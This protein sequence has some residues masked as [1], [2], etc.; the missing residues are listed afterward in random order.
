MDLQILSDV[1]IPMRDAIC[2]LLQPLI[3]PFSAATARL[4]DNNGYT[5]EEDF[6]VV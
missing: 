2:Q 6:C 3:A 4:V 5:L 1:T